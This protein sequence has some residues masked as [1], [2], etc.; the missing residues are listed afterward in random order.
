MHF[1]NNLFLITYLSML[2][3]SLLLYFLTVKNITKP[4]IITFVYFFYLLFAYFGIPLLYYKSIPYY[5]DIEIVNKTTIWLMLLVSGSSLIFMLLGAFVARL[6]IEKTYIFPT[7]KEVNKGTLIF[8]PIFLFIFSIVILLLYLRSLESI[9]LIEAVKGLG[10]EKISQTRFYATAGSEVKY[11]WISFFIHEC[12]PFLSFLFLGNYLLFKKKTHLTIF[13][14]T[15]PITLFSSVIEA[16]KAPLV[17]LL[18]GLFLAGWY[19]EKINLGLKAVFS[20]GLLS[21]VLLFVLYSLFMPSSFWL[22]NI[23]NPLQRATASQIASSYFYLEYFPKE[24]SFLLGR[25][26]PNP[27]NI[28]PYKNYPLAV[29]MMD[30]LNP[31]LATKGLSGSA[32]TVFW[33]EIYANFGFLPIPFVSFFIGTLLYFAETFFK[34][35]KLSPLKVAL[36]S[37][38]TLFASRISM[39]SLSTM[40]LTPPLFGIIFIT[41]ILQGYL[42]LKKILLKNKGA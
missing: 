28:F 22:K 23:A 3:L 26:F 4:S 14:L 42:T 2:V 32:N 34:A 27:K 19:T 38:I 8:L 11:N 37:W 30:F 21:L 12:I 41:L 7:K 35:G 36:F 29:K 1:L 18:F 40:I 6:I 16:R 25:S 10:G 17:L 15:L 13:L 5:V 24:K 39:T 9:P 31:S 33:A 20:L